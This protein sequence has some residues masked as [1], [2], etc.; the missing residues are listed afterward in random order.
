M[1]S[2]SKFPAFVAMKGGREA[3]LFRFVEKRSHRKAIAQA[4]P[5]NPTPHVPV[6]LSGRRVVAR[7]IHPPPAQDDSEVVRAARRDQSSVAK[8]RPA[9]GTVAVERWALALR[10]LARHFPSA[11]SPGTLHECP[12]SLTG[13][14][15][16]IASARRAKAHR[17]TVV[18]RR[19]VDVCIWR[20]ASARNGKSEFSVR[21][22]VRGS[23]AGDLRRARGFTHLIRKLFE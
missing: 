2:R 19:S 16:L 7:R 13:F 3:A 15:T 21:P 14:D 23:R 17:S 11:V 12:E 8:E 20:C 6:I 9:P 10:A 18:V 1:F 22:I 5:A 4:A